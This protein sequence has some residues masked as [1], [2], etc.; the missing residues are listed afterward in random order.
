MT[1][2]DVLNNLLQSTLHMTTNAL[3]DLSDADLQHHPVPGAN[4]IAW[5]LGHLIAA[6]TQL[7]AMLNFPYPEL[8]A[9]LAGL[10]KTETNKTRPDGGN[11]P[12][13]DYIAWFTKVRQATLAGL[14]K[15]TDADLSKPNTGAMKEFAPTLGTVL[16]LVA[17][18]TMM[19]M[20]QFSVV[21]RAL[22]KPVLM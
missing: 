13:A 22:K 14:A 8:P 21:R 9:P 4:N 1:G 16:V 5:Q 20:G 11:L 15:M 3:N 7:G 10:G 19:H 17:N 2:K 6:E 12:K 18:H